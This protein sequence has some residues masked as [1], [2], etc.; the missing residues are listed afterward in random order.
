MDVNRSS[1]SLHSR[2]HLSTIG[3]SHAV[4]VDVLVP[5]CIWILHA[6]QELSHTLGMADRTIFVT[7]KQSAEVSDLVVKLSNLCVEVVILG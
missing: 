6:A 3:H 4:G 7:H 1:A 2:L 5:K